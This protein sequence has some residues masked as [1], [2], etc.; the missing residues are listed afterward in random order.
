[1]SMRKILIALFS[2]LSLPALA[3]SGERY[4]NARFGYSLSVPEGFVGL[5]ESDNG[6]GQQ[7]GLPGRA[8]ALNV[9][10]GSVSDF[11]AEVASRMAQDTT[12]GWNQTYQSLTP[13]WASWSAT[14]AGKVLYQRMILL[15]DGQ[16]YAAFRAEYGMRDRA[17]MDPVVENLAASLHGQAC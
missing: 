14:S 7:F 1:M 16:S 4:D 15:C 17:E 8:I 6:D 9:W 2:L 10:G 5:G 13:R 12:E 3:Q 11:E